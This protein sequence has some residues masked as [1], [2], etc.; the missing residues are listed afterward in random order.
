MSFADT[1]FSPVFAD[2]SLIVV[3]KPAGLLSVP[4]RG[5]DKQDALSTRVQAHYHD[6]LIVHRL[7]QP[8]SGLMVMARGAA[9]QRALSTAFESRA[10][11]KY[12]VTVVQGIVQADSGDITAPLRADWPARPRQMVDI[13]AGKPSHTYWQVLARNTVDNTT[14]MALQPLTGRT[15]QL[16]VHCMHIGHPIV[17]DAIYSTAHNDTATHA[18]LL[19]HAQRLALVHPLTMQAMQ[20]DCPA[21]F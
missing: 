20:W 6:A 4:G 13:T 17:G 7:D 9:M 15:H 11:H 2:D 14:R 19:L 8:T 10:V 16:R 12:Y 1:A 18:R 5:A 3:N 21:D